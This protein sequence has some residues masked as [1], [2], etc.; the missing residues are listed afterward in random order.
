MPHRR[1]EAH[2]VERRAHDRI[3]AAPI[4]ELTRRKIDRR[5]RFALRRCMENVAHNADD[6]A[7]GW[8]TRHSIICVRL[9]FLPQS[10]LSRKIVLCESLVYDHDLRRTHIVTVREVP[11]FEEGDLHRAEIAGRDRRKLSAGLPPLE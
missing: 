6:L 8:T 9:Q 4:R 10:I 2:R 7:P 3:Q 5:K 1:L 11:A